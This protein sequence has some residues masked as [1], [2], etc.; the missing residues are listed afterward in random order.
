MTAKP[1]TPLVIIAL[2]TLTGCASDPAQWLNESRCS[3]APATPTKLPAGLVL[4]EKG[5]DPLPAKEF[6]PRREVDPEAGIL[7]AD[8]DTVE[9]TGDIQK[10]GTYKIGKGTTITLSELLSQA[11]GLGLGPHGFVNVTVTSGTN[12]TLHSIGSHAGQPNIPSVDLHDGDHVN[13]RA[14]PPCR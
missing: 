13:I 4:I 6:V 3:T 11:G 9:L 8:F 14:Q 7:V 10:T 12:V 2:C 1:T 5:A